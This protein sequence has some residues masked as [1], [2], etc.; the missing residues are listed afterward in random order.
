M[1]LRTAPAL[2][3][4]LI[5][6]F[7]NP[8]G[9]ASAAPAKC[10]AGVLPEAKAAETK[11]ASSAVIY[12][13]PQGKD[14]WSG[15][16]AQPD[17]QES[18]G[19]LASFEAARDAARASG[20]TATI[21]VRGGDYYLARPVLFGPE[22]TGLSIVARCGEVPIL[23]GGS[24]VK[25]WEAQ[26]DG[27]WTAQLKLPPGEVV[28][29]LFVGGEIQTQARFPNAPP[30]GDPRKGWLFADKLAVDGWQGNMQ[31]RFHAGDLTT[32]PDTA[33]LVA[34]IVGGFQPGSQWGSDTLPVVSI[35]TASRTIHTKGTAYFFTGEGSR[36]FL[37]NAK[38][39]LDAP[40]EWWYDGATGVLTYIPESPSFKDAPVVAGILPTLFR[41][42]HADRMTISGLQFRDGAPQ[43]TGKF[44]TETRGFGAIRLEHSD[45]V[46]LIGNDIGNVGVGIHVSESRDVLIADNEIGNI[47]GNAIYLG[48]TY[49]SFGRSDGAQ[50]LSNH[51]HDVG[52]VYFESAGIWF[53]AA[54]KVHIARNRIERTAQFGIAGGSIWGRDDAVH[55]AIIEQN[56]VTDAN[57]QT[58]DGGAIKMMGEQQ[59]LL[60]SVIRNNRVTG[61]RQLMN[62]TDGTFWPPDYENTGEWPSP[63]SWA[64]YTDGKASGVRIEGN[65]VSDNVAGIGINGGFNNVITGNVIRQGTG[66]AFRIDDGTGRDWHPPWGQPNRIEDNTVSIDGGDHLA[67]SIYAP[68]HGADYVKFARNRYSGK[69]GPKSFEMQPEIMETG[70][71]GSLA[72][73]QKAGAD[74]G[75]TFET[76][77]PEKQAGSDP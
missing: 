47:A 66:A 29:D 59:D 67:V 51:I 43:G 6:P 27:S 55:D 52:R 4:A 23:H 62:R 77:G 56:D 1:R 10:V 76:T 16:L 69:L 22:D 15:H 45:K 8:A 32:L 2:G 25:T 19:P 70:R 40:R 71:Q 17:A 48:T 50:I 63:I 9:A 30:D 21:V 34:H 53:Q 57:Q 13:S 42:D 39:F 26:P 49:G 11:P 74:S 24:L 72:D 61:T 75:S 54:D 68:G 35:D 58:A 18:D 41:L 73:F 37:A 5:L 28:G 46:K 7:A 3:F 65:V 44:G 33:G 60:N 64:I 31:F 36:Y 38:V 14:S 20:G 12:V